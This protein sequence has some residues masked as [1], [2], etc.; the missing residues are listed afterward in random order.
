[1]TKLQA[2]SARA[3]LVSGVAVAALLSG[4][5]Y[6]Q[7]AEPVRDPAA[8]GTEVQ[9]AEEAQESLDASQPVDS[10]GT[11]KEDASQ[12]VVTGTLVR[13]I[14]PPGTNVI[15]VTAADVEATGATTTAQ[16]LQTIPQL[17]SFNA[18]QQPIAGGNSVTVNRPN[19]R[20]LPGFNNSGGSTTLVLMDGHRIVGAGIVTTTPDP[21]IIP[22]GSIERLEIVPDG[23]S[24]IYG[25]DAIAGVLN[26]ITLKR[27]DGI[28]VDGHY[29]FADDYHQ[30]D[31]N[32]TA[33]RDWGTGSAY[34]AYTYAEHGNLFGRDRDYIRQFPNQTPNV[35]TT[36][37][38]NVTCSPGNVLI[39]STF[40][41]LPFAT[42]AAARA[43]VPNQC[44]GNDNST[45]YPS[46]RRHS[47]LAGLS[48][49]F[50]DSITVDMRG[51]YTHRRTTVTGGPFQQSVNISNNV[52]NMFYPTRRIGTEPLPT[53]ANPNPTVQAV[54]YRFGALDGAEQNVTLETWGL[55]PTVTADLGGGWQLRVLGSYS[56]SDT[57]SIID[58]FNPTG[59]ANA[60][61]NGLF[62]PY[63]PSTSNATALGTILNDQGYARTRQRLANAR[64]VIDGELFALPGGG[65]KLAAGV[66]YIRENFRTRA[67]ANRIPGDELTGAPSVS[68]NG[69]LLHPATTPIALVDLKRNVKSVFGEVVV[70]I[71]GAD[72]ATTLLR[73]LTFSAAGRY[74]DYNDVGST[75][76]PKFGL[77][78]RPIDWIKLRAAYGE[79]FNAPSLADAPDATPFTTFLV[80]NGQN[81][82]IASLRVSGGGTYPDPR[83]EQVTVL[84]FRGNDPNIAPQTA[85]TLSFGIDVQPPFI[86]GLNLSATYF[87]IKLKNVIG[88]PPA[89][90]TQ[91]VYRE[92]PSSITVNPTAAQI[93]AV[94]ALSPNPP[95]L[96]GNV[97]C[98][99]QVQCIYAITNVTKQNLGDFN[100]EGLDVNGSYHL[101]TGFGGLNFGV[102]ANYEFTREQKTDPAIAT[103]VDLLAA[104]NSRFKLRATA[105]AEIGNFLAQATFSHTEGYDL[106]PA[107]GF[108]GTTST[109][110][111]FTSQ[112]MVGDFNVFDLFFRYDFEGDGLTQDLQLTLNVNNVFDKDPP[113]FR[114]PQSGGP[115]TGII[116]GSTLGR[117]VQFGISKKF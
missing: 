86:Q 114:G 103:V 37:L 79:S 35:A 77:T 96:I 60:I 44:D 19:L 52:L 101:D 25:S 16:L 46:E 32:L 88:L 81:L 3:A 69:V 68:F 74:D 12:I 5:A 102:N 61:N 104:N 6:A 21:D 38:L 75:F 72:N 97:G 67:A 22:A 115:G 9:T 100:L 11:T 108:V 15:G 83:P 106:D 85:K 117:L 93:A 39:G 58:T 62:N 31:T 65:V 105:G 36:G 50:T 94:L 33:G 23:G 95:N 42:G 113:V 51:F 110:Q 78:Y 30:L 1:M 109:G 54:S 34:V 63:D 10:E 41:P 57:K 107:I 20:S 7:V 87:R 76:N 112:T 84:S 40:Y 14:A 48:Q 53:A 49:E 2:G 18:L 47:V 27:F 92:F 26:F 116:N 90:N 98:A 73:E 82:P 29:G 111:T 24:A 71:F 43:G 8:P 70:P 80:G 17:G 91:Q 89:Q 45:F 13:G 28:K 55:T 59:L 66:E 99:P 64:A 56:R 4:S